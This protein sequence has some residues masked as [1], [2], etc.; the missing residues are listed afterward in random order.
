MIG[1]WTCNA[2]ITTPIPSSPLDASSAVM[3]PGS[4]SQ[5]PFVMETAAVSHGPC[6]AENALAPFLWSPGWVFVQFS[7]RPNSLLL[8]N[9]RRLLLLAARQDHVVGVAIRLG[10]NPQ[11]SF[12]EDPRHRR[13]CTHLQGQLVGAKP[14]GTSPRNPHHTLNTHPLPLP[15]TMMTFATPVAT[16]YTYIR[17]SRMNRPLSVSSS[18]CLRLSLPLRLQHVCILRYITCNPSELPAATRRRGHV[19]HRHVLPWGRGMG[20]ARGA[21]EE[22]GMVVLRNWVSESGFW[23]GFFFGCCV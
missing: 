18:R 12:S 15:P 20:W 1:S 8:D 5:L 19:S 10:G 22:G 4:S 23:K 16:L 14:H 11:C 2:N 17:K 7:P 6:A 21:G 13:L 9:I 3:T